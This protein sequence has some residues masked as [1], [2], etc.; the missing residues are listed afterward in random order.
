ME[1]DHAHAHRCVLS[2]EA[3]SYQHPDALLLCA[4]QREELADRYGHP[5]SERGQPP[6]EQDIAV[7]LVAYVSYP[8]QSHKTPVACG[9]LRSL[10]GHE[11]IGDAEIKRM[12]VKKHFRGTTLRPGLAILQALEAW[13]LNKGWTRLVLETG[14]LL[15]EALRFYPKY[16]Y[17]EIPNFGPYDGVENSVCFGKQLKTGFD[18]WQVAA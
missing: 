7:F 2:I 8:D 9:G 11:V 12:F 14:K 1:A 6:S 17:T 4:S 15:P 5:Y 16:G 3:M 18:E 13:A 10:G